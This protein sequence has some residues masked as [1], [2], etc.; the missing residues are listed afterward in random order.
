MYVFIFSKS[1]LARILCKLLLLTMCK[2][3]CSHNTLISFTYYT[4]TSITSNFKKKIKIN[5]LF[6]FSSTRT[7]NLPLTRDPRTYKP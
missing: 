3:T 2:V 4:I 5:L 1:Q 7:L 6:H